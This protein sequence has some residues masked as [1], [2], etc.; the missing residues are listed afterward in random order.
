MQQS[1]D[2]VCHSLGQEA[3]AL[4]QQGISDYA[5]ERGLVL[6]AVFGKGT[7]D[8]AEVVDKK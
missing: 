2:A 7:D 4:L 6:P 3:L 8:I 1:I 5:P